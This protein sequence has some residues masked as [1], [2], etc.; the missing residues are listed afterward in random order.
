[1]LCYVI[2]DHSITFSNDSCC[3]FDRVLYRSISCSLSFCKSEELI[4]MILE[5]FSTDFTVILKLVIDGRR[6]RRALMIIRV[7]I[8]TTARVYFAKMILMICLKALY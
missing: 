2:T 4:G 7:L 3:A 5:D 8:W 6:L 1:M